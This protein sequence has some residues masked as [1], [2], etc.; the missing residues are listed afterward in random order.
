MPAAMSAMEIPGLDGLSGVPVAI[1][2]PVSHCTS[3]S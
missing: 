2:R 1:T 3:R